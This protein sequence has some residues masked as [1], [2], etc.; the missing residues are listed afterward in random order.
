MT[1]PEENQEKTPK[2]DAILSPREL[3]HPP[4]T[5]NPSRTR[6]PAEG[7]RPPRPPEEAEEE[8]RREEA[9][10]DDAAESQDEDKEE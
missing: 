3:R 7:L 4:S 8:G 6:V 10:A 5:A 1:E 2:T 9:A